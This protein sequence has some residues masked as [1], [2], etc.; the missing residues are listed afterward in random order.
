ME[1]NEMFHQPP[2]WLTVLVVSAAMLA[3]SAEGQVPTQPPNIP[4]PE[5]IYPPPKSP[6][7][8][9]SRFGEK[10]SRPAEPTNTTLQIDLFA[11]DPAQ[12]L[13][14]QSWGRVFDSLG[15]R[16]RIRTGG[17]EDEP[18]L[19]ESNRG[20]LRTVTLVGRIDR[21]GTL[22]FPGKKFN[23]GDDKAL[24]DWLE[25]L[26]SYGAQGSPVGQPRWGLNAGQ[27]QDLFKTLS[28]V[29][30]K[31]VTGQPLVDAVRSFGF[32]IDIPLRIHDT[33][34]ERWNSKEPGLVALQDVRG[35]TRGSA[36]AVL[37]ND[38]DLCFRPMRTPAGTI[39]LVVLEK[40][41]TPDPWPLGWEPRPDVARDEY[42]PALF[43]FGPIG[44]L[45][46][47]V[48]ETL[49]DAHQQ[50]GCAVV[51][52]TPALLKKDVD[53]SKKRFG[54]PEKKTAW[55]LILKSAL[56]GTGLLPHIRI[57]EAG[58]GFVLVAPFESKSVS[59]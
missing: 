12:A 48:T 37:L 7:P 54:V 55:I 3:R 25:E 43:A 57:D 23:A 44:F 42:A 10:P 49:A 32:G 1:E 56:T 28:E 52:D 31:D 41:Q 19:S 45:D 18:K 2:A 38:H 35:L 6:S 34:S 27:F 29:I 20:P 15:H 4:K 26:Q 14:S 21:R 47:P 11:S 39:D 58:R 13:E 8:P 16:V 40:T 17:V 33:V 30:E 59:R 36:L 22:S 5:R 50:T 51:V 24:K 9:Q 46:R 53:L